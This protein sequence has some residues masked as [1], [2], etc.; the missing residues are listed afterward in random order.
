MEIL[1][2][3]A[4]YFSPTGNAKKIAQCVASTAASMLNVPC[5]DFD[6]TLPGARSGIHEYGEGDLVAF[7]MPVYAGR[8]PNKILPYVESGF[9][10]NGA[11]A[12]I[13]SSYGNR[14]FGDAL[15][16]LNLTLAAEGFDIVAAAAMP[17]EH[18]FTSALA[19]GRPDEEDLRELEDFTRK[20][21]KKIKEESLIVPPKVP[22]NNPVGPYYTPVGIDGKPAQ[23]LKAKPCTNV[24]KCDNCGICAALCPMGSI[25]ALDC[26]EVPGT[27]IK[28]QSCI[29]SCPKGAKYLDDEAF[30]SH[31]A[32]L[33][34]NY[35][36]PKENL[37]LL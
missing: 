9:A 7:C 21:V 13:V 14:D 12:I 24:E 19:T 23:F 37:F 32:M 3:T 11:K 17:S 35:T 36:A 1:R 33:R 26:V 30:L 28:C 25:D 20:A 2:V 22:G 16:E 31:V 29:R 27:C 18:A 5:D 15:M 8:L 34:E 6:F 10:G 4:I